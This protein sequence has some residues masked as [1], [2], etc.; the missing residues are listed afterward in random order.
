MQALCGTLLFSLTPITPYQL[1]VVLNCWWYLLGVTIWFPITQFVPTRRLEFCFSGGTP[2]WHVTGINRLLGLR[3]P[4]SNSWMASIEVSLWILLAGS[5]TW[6]WQPFLKILLCC[7]SLY[8]IFFWSE[9]FYLSDAPI[10]FSPEISTITIIFPILGYS[11]GLYINHINS[12]QQLVIKLFGLTYFPL[13][14]SDLENCHT[15]HI[16]GI[17]GKMVYLS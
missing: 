5:F 2:D 4:C 6:L 11:I 1:A 10:L 15:P 7:A 13:S 16:H 14:L 3:H 8:V 9:R 17:W 12:R